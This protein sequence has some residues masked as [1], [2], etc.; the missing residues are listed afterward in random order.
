MN[1]FHGR[2]AALR[3]LVRVPYRAPRA[4]RKRFAPALD[5]LEARTLLSALV[6]TSTNDSGPG[7][8]RQAIADASSGETITFSSKLRGQTITLTSGELDISNSIKIDGLGASQLAVSG[9][10]SNRVF[11]INSGA[12]V[13]ISGLTI[14]DGLAT[15]GA[16]VVNQGTLTLD[17]CSVTSNQANF[18]S[19]TSLVGFAGFGGGLE[20]LTGATLTIKDSTVSGNQ[21]VGEASF[22]GLANGGGIANDGV[23]TIVDSTVSHNQALAANETIVGSEAEGGGIFLIN[24]L[25]GGPSSLTMIDSV[26]SDNQ[27]VGGSPA[28]SSIFGG[29]AADGGGIFSEDGATLSITG[30]TVDGN[31]ALGGTGGTFGQAFGGAIDSLGAAI[32]ITHCT[33]ANNQAIGGADGTGITDEGALAEGG[34]IFGENNFLTI[35]GSSFTGNLA[36]GGLGSTGVF[37]L[38]GASSGGALSYEQGLSTFNGVTTIGVLTVTGVRSPT[39]RPSAAT[40]REV[41][42]AALTGAP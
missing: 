33:V 12:V 42:E 17:G 32:T 22:I 29:G 25:A 26:L 9:G 3:D 41:V 16:G 1:L 19:N 20:N 21:S 4:R 7:S 35:T 11:Q 2:S 34:A 5:A 8:L 18:D 31:Q 24:P 6:V 40:A 23:L 15:D 14:T 38:G 13:T 30:S 28:G 10:G 27:A 39:I 36:E 37:G